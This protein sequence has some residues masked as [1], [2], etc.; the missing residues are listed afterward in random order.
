MWHGG[1]WDQAELAL[2]PEGGK[3]LKQELGWRSRDGRFSKD[4]MV[5]FGEPLD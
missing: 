5:R 2:S 1:R 4:L 3:P